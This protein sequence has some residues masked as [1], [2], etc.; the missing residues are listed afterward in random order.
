MTS[1]GPL[2]AR[3]QAQAWRGDWAIPV[4]PLGPDTWDCTEHAAGLAGYLDDCAR[5]QQLTLEQGVTDN[6]DCFQ[7]DPAAPGWVR[8]WQGPFTITTTREATR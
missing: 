7:R 6:D 8:E 2:T 1:D 3:F 5:N 4:C